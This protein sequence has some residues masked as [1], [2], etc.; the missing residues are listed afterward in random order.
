MED[1]KISKSWIKEHALDPWFFT[2]SFM[3]I[4]NSLKIF[5]NLELGVL[6]LLKIIKNW[7]QRF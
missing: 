6:F 5:K 3:R 1:L 2:D 7:N 4:I